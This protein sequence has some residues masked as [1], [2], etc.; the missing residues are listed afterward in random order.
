[1]PEGARRLEHGYLAAIEGAPDRPDA[2][3][4]ISDWNRVQ[5]ALA[6]VPTSGQCIRYIGR[7]SD[8]T[9]SGLHRIDV[10]ICSA[11]IFD[12]DLV[13]CDRTDSEV[14]ILIDGIALPLYFTGGSLCHV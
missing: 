13:D 14:F 8:S 1:M 11:S 9:V 3:G 5:M 4:G 12:D 6:T 2:N 7:G 10:K